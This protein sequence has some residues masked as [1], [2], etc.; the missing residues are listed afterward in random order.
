MANVVAALIN[1]TGITDADLSTLSINKAPVAQ[2]NGVATQKNN[3]IFIDDSF[4][5]KFKF[6][7]FLNVI[8]AI[9]NKIKIAPAYTFSDNESEKKNTLPNIENNGNKLIMTTNA[10]PTF[11]CLIVKMKSRS[12]T[13]MKLS[14][15]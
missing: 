12:V 7:L 5:T 9:P 6:F 2:N 10:I 15:H 14:L 13:K 4:S 11:T 3:A 8:D 1:V